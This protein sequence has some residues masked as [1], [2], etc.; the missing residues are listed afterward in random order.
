M[1][2][3]LNITENYAEKLLQVSLKWETKINGKAHEIFSEK[4]TGP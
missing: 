4:I 1:I 3:T 2:S